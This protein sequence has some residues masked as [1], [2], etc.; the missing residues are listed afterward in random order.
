MASWPELSFTQAEAVSLDFG[1]IYCR[2]EAQPTYL[3][4]FLKKYSLLS[5]SSFGACL[6]LEVVI[7]FLVKFILDIVPFFWRAP[8]R[9]PVSKGPHFSS[10]PGDLY[11]IGPDK[12]SSTLIGRHKP[13]AVRIHVA[14]SHWWSSVWLIVHM[15]RWFFHVVQKEPCQ[16][17]GNSLNTWTQD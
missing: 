6:H 1:N 13:S 7:L 8:S 11:R 9:R 12:H 15:C 14:S 5:L 4:Q 3:S 16:T 10:F 2:F 17:V